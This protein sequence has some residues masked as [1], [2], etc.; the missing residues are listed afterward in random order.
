MVVK[1]ILC[2]CNANSYVGLGHLSRMINIVGHLN[3]L[4]DNLIIT[5]YG[6]YSEFGETL[7]KANELKYVNEKKYKSYDYKGLTKIISKGI[8]D[9]IIVDTYL[10]NEELLNILKESNLRTLV[11]D[12]LNTL[13]FKDIDFLL[14]FTVGSIN[15]NYKSKKT[16]KGLKYFP[17]KHSLLKIRERNKHHNLK[18]SGN[19]YN[20]YVIL[21]GSS[22][23]RDKVL[24]VLE[25][26]E[27]IFKDARLIYIDSGNEVGYY[28]GRTVIASPVKEMEKV[29]SNADLIINGG[30]LLKYEA[31]FCLIPNISI[32]VND[33]GLADIHIF[34]EMGLTVYAGKLSLENKEEIKEKIK[35]FVMNKESFTNKLKENSKKHFDIF[36]I[37]K[38]LNDFIDK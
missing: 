36:G 9:N 2:Y 6:N 19:I 31:A 27:T 28:A 7:L 29:L 17:Y 30:G 4:Q 14:N 3:T 32:M 5:F 1:R 22:V 33:S 15:S 23:G 12:D 25:I 8:Y 38:A 16:F 21:S 18:K 11:I 24:M 20:V 35:H 13:D 10:V 34:E 37:R 26:V